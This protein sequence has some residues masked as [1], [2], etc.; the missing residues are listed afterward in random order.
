MKEAI[1]CKTGVNCGWKL[2][3]VFSL[4]EE[5]TFYKILKKDKD[6]RVV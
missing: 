3:N 4:R 2:T 6:Y 5:H 1:Y